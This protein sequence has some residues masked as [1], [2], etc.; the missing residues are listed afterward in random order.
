MI[1]A[2]FRKS[3]IWYTALQRE[4]EKKKK[5]TFWVC[6]RL[7]GV[8][9]STG[10]LTA[11]RWDYISRRH[12]SFVTAAAITASLQIYNCLALISGTRVQMWMARVNPLY[13][14]GLHITDDRCGHYGG[15]VVLCP[16]P[17]HDCSDLRDPGAGTITGLSAALGQGCEVHIYYLCRK[18]FWL[19][20]IWFVILFGIE[21]DCFTIGEQ[22]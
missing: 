22:L 10:A 9:V 15:D 4:C 18:N 6:V 12:L 7:K 2:I 17:R 14:D 21:K 8:G 13:F 19:D 16:W 20:N 11:P 3:Y 1:W 5:D